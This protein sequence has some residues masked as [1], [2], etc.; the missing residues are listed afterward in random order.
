MLTGLKQ[1][2]STHGVHYSVDQGEDFATVGAPATTDYQQI[3][4]T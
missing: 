1:K 3:E 2:M 4:M